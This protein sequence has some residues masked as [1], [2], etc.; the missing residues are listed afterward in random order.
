MLRDKIEILKQKINAN[1]VEREQVSALILLAALSKEHT[2]LI[3]LPGTAKSF[4]AK[5]LKDV[6][7]VNEEHEY[8]ERLLTRFSVP[9]E[10]FG[11]L[12]LKELENDN[13]VRKID[14]FL[15]TAKIAFL[16]EIFKANS[17]IL[18]SLLSILNERLFDQGNQRITTPLISLIAASNELPS[19]EEL[20]ALFDRF[21]MRYELDYVSD[22]QF[23]NLLEYQDQ[24]QPILAHEK[25]TFDELKEIQEKS[26][27]VLIHPD[28]RK[29]L[30]QMKKLF[31]EK[32]IEVSDRRWIKIIHILKVSA[33]CQDHP[34]VLL[35]DLFLLPWMIFSNQKDLKELISIVH[36]EIETSLNFDNDHYQAIF[37]AWETQFEINQTQKITA[38]KIQKDL[39]QIKEQLGDLVEHVKISLLDLKSQLTKKHLWLSTWPMIDIEDVE[40]ALNKQE[41]EAGRVNTLVQKFKQQLEKINK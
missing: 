25:I 8:L 32:K 24:S 1:L 33:Y 12:S 36:Q 10:L 15:P 17:A 26:K 40:N 16:D 20:N 9:E 41:K 4:L 19:T 39:Q 18:N 3:G 37:E 31:M 30:K 6:F 38:D 7:E 29:A 22:D 21:L 35:T 5:K 11:P 23:R 34:Q 14:G 28:T 2:L 27:N 13:Y